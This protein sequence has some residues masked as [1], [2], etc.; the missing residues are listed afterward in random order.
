MSKLVTE[1]IESTY[2]FTVV[3]NTIN[4]LGILTVFQKSAYG[5]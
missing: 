2:I 5:T 1:K 4:Y 3:I